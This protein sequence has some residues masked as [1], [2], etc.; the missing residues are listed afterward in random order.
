MRTT[1]GQ[2]H[3]AHLR[4]GA[5][6]VL[7]AAATKGQRVGFRIGGVE[8]RAIDGHEPIAAKEGARHAFWLGDQ[9]TALAHEGLQALAPQ[10]LAASTE[11]RITQSALRLARMQRAS[12]SDQ[13]LP[14]LALVHTTPQR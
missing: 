4:I 10:F 12:L 9:L 7:I 5:W 14:D 6:P 1:L 13:A 3:T 8:Q 2:E 11:P